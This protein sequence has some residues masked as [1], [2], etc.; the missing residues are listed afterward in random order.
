MKR[1]GDNMNTTSELSNLKNQRMGKS[2]WSIASLI[3]LTSALFAPL[4]LAQDTVAV[5]PID[6]GAGLPTAESEQVWN[7]LEERGDIA[8]IAA[9]LVAE[10]L[11]Y[12]YG[13]PVGA[14]L[15]W[16]NYQVSEGEDA[17]YEMRYDD[18]I[19][20]FSSAEFREALEAIIDMGQDPEIAMALRRGLMAQ[21]RSE[22][23]S[24]ELDAAEETIRESLR[25][26]PTWVPTTDWY[27][28]DFVAAFEAARGQYLLATR[29][30]HVYTGLP[31]C[32]VFING[33]E[34]EV[35]LPVDLRVV[36]GSYAIVV[37]CDEIVSA[38]HRVNV[39]G[40]RS[41][42]INLQTDR[43]LSPSDE[44]PGEDVGQLGEFGPMGLAAAEILDVERV[45]FVSMVAGEDDTTRIQLVYTDGLV[46]QVLSAIQA[47]MTVPAREA[48]SALLDHTEVDG[49][50]ASQSEEWADWQDM[51]PVKPGALIAFGVG[52]AGLIVGTIFAVL[53]GNVYDDFR[54]CR[55]DPFC[56][57]TDR[58]D[59]YR[60]E[61]ELDAILATVG[62]SVGI[63]GVVTGVVLILVDSNPDIPTVDDT[64]T[65]TAWIPSVR[66]QPFADGGF[67][68]MDWTF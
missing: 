51:S 29:N 41:V 39:E 59:E 30:L 14:N 27:Q 45:L 26:F 24:G 34:N 48:V 22:F 65:D 8:I 15:E 52:G 36:E 47:E 31:D 58:L 17:Y 37:A 42:F 2:T 64:D 53:E 18:S 43:Y 33:I 12:R 54:D 44:S 50:W 10:R 20:T 56:S 16:I 55:D 21:A 38:V 67:V 1:L 61:A 40:D 23:Y 6:L 7:A 11:D 5:V 35:P 68:Q 4:A 66:A 49:V 60:S 62:F 13:Y 57:S 19:A 28:P 46:G 9:D 3:I 25:L 32:R 63:A